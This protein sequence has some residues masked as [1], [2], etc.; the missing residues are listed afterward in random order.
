MSTDARDQ[1]DRTAASYAVSPAHSTSE[2]L[3]LLKEFAG[4]RRYGVALDIATGPGFTAFAV[5]DQCDHVI[6]SD[7]SGGMLEQVAVL[8]GERGHKNV[9][10]AFADAHSLP[11]KDASF[12]LVTCRTAPHHFASIPTF[13]S[14]SRRV[15]GD[16]G[17]LLLADTTTSED[18]TARAWHQEMEARRDPSHVAAPTPPG[19]R[20]ALEDAGFTITGQ[21]STTVDMTFNDWVLRSKTPAGEVEAI[22]AAWAEIDEEVAR[23]Y[24]V[25]DLDDGDFSFSWPVIVLR[26]EVTR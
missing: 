11:F 8:A 17:V 22:R 1:F 4:D 5:A 26:A 6:A 7:I 14:E 2:S 21:A 13:L 10:R 16:A 24:L 23:E 25:R 15:L 20:D 18:E 19:W 9:G 3:R 12:D